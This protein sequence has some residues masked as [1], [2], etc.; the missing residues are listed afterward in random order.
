MWAALTE[1]E[2]PGDVSKGGTAPRAVE[3]MPGE[4]RGLEVRRLWSKKKGFGGSAGLKDR[5]TEASGL[6]VK[7]AAVRGWAAGTRDFSG[8]GLG[9]CRQGL[10][11]EVTG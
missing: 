8:C 11:C 6:E 9:R 2:A 3:A 4:E 10:G 7:E 5:D 1:G